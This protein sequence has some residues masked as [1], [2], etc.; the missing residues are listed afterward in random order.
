MASQ[1]FGGVVLRRLDAPALEP[2]MLVLEAVIT[3]RRDNQ[4]A[5]VRRLIGTAVELGVAG[6]TMPR[7]GLQ[8]PAATG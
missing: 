3:W 8:A 1:G 5:T 2:G 4:A 6:E 7:E